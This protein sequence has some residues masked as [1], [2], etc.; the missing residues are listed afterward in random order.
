MRRVVVAMAVV[1][2]AAVAVGAAAVVVAAAVVEDGARLR[3]REAEDG[4]DLL[5]VRGE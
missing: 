2:V 4:V 1:A 3:L 5:K